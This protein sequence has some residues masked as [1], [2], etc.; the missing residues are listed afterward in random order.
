MLKNSLSFYPFTLIF[1]EEIIDEVGY[2]A[3]E[4][5]LLTGIEPDPLEEEQK[6]R[7]RFS[8]LIFQEFTAG[9]FAATQEAVSSRY[10]PQIKNTKKIEMM[11]HRKSICHLVKSSKIF[12][13]Y[14][15]F[16][17][18]VVNAYAHKRG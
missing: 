12:S 8:H 7:F 18:S 1:Q 17:T 5:G 4:L 2:E 10:C 9:K 6:Q 16:H 11:F 3:F 13:G 14:G 15:L